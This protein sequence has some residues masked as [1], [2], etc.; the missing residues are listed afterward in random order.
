VPDTLG[1][2]LHAAAPEP[3]T[4]ESVWV[5]L[6]RATGGGDQ[7]AFCDLYGRMHVI[8]F[9]L[10]VRIVRNTET[11]EELTV[12]VFHDVWR[13]AASYDA[14]GGTV[15]GWVMNQARSRAI[16]RTRF[17]RRKKRVDPYP[18]ASEPAIEGDAGVDI[19]TR[20]RGKQLRAAVADL[21]PGERRAIESSYFDDCTYAETATRLGEPAGTVK[22]RIRS[23]LEKLR[24]TLDRDAEA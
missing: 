4:A 8:V 1:A 18:C 13:R 14:A 16:D 2:L 21:A 3:A 17:E 10:I 22:S 11:A 20:A 9:T 5:D 6:V 7:H 12:D 15:I 24:R 23:G 19:D